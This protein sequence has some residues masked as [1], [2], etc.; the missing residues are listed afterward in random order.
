MPRP[1]IIN[2]RETLE[3]VDRVLAQDFAG[4]GRLRESAAAD[5][6][7][8]DRTLAAV[9]LRRMCRDPGYARRVETPRPSD[10]AWVAGRLAEGVPVFRIRTSAFGVFLALRAVHEDW[11][12]LADMIRRLEAR[13]A[14]DGRG[15]ASL[16]RLRRT[17]ERAHQ[18]EPDA[19]S[20]AVDRGLERATHETGDCLFRMIAV[21]RA[22]ARNGVLPAG[23]EP[24]D[25]A[26]MAAV[27]AAPCAIGVRGGVWRLCTTL[28]EVEALGH[29][30]GNCLARIAIDPCWRAGY[31]AGSR[32]VWGFWLGGVAVGVAEVDPAGTLVEARG[33][34][35]A[36]WPEAHED[37]LRVLLEGLPRKGVAA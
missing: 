34:A 26:E 2:V 21:L 15:R 8:R 23:P 16:A 11:C 3:L 25:A 28:R 22:D 14:E 31:V 1:V 37:A 17:R 36:E 33:R 4:A 6:I 20:R 29:A 5:R 24:A 13:V 19:L 10:P 9:A 35:N 27:F 18:M 32:A 12:V 30:L 7:L